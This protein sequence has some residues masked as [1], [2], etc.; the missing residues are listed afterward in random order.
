MNECPCAP[1]LL[2]ATPPNQSSGIFLQEIGQN[3]I[4]LLCSSTLTPTV[5]IYQN[6]IYNYTHKTTQNIGS[7]GMAHPIADANPLCL[8][9]HGPPKEA[10]ET[11]CCK[12]FVKLLK[13]QL[14]L[15]CKF[16]P[17]ALIE[18]GLIFE[19]AQEPEIK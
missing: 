17:H 2:H 16:I 11:Y 5:P 15:F 12:K 18:Q 6:I 13:N 7:S 8:L 10:L 4:T 1:V 9:H 3:F 14:E 19:P